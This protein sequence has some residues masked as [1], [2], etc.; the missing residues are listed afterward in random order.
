MKGIA[1]PI[2]LCVTHQHQDRGSLY[3]AQWVAQSGPLEAADRHKVNNIHPSHS[4]TNLA[5]C[6]AALFCPHVLLLLV[7]QLWSSVCPSSFPSCQFWAFWWHWGPYSS[8]CPSSSFCLPL[9]LS[10]P[11]PTNLERGGKQEKREVFT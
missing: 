11:C 1:S 7:V 10:S 2:H 4:S 3:M 6:S 9:A 8:S 5:H